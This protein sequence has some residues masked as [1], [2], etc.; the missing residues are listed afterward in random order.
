MS[1]ILEVNNL[2]V[3]D[4]R[5]QDEII[6]D[7]SFSVAKNS[8]LG[9]VGESGSGKSMITRALLGITNPW[10]KHQGKAVFKT[11]GEAIDL[12]RQNEDTLREIRGKQIAMILQDAMSAFDPITRI[13]DQMAET[14]V[15]NKGLTKKQSMTLAKEALAVM[16]IR[17]PEQVIKKYSHQLSGGML[18]RCMIATALAMEPELIIA[19]EPTT[20]LDSINQGQV[21][22]EFQIIRQKIGTALIF[23]SHDLGVVK[24]LSDQLLV[25]K[26][27]VAVEYGDAVDIFKNPRHAY[28][29]Y[30]IDTRLELT[31]AFQLA[32]KK[33]DHNG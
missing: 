9:I 7:I 1:V 5:D 28:T 19:D 3:T 24:H 18:Q 22:E 13:G 26:D 16:N 21:V 4:S 8:C 6:H 17:E 29:R 15:E 27:G 20:A 12:L 30:L 25:M 10:L 11:S 32:M 23:I 31:H 14:F 33:G 2:R